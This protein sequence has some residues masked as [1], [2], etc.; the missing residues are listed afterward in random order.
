[1]GLGISPD[2]WL[3]V[4]IIGFD[5]GI[6]VLPELLDGGEGGAVQG[7]SFKDREPD[8]DLI[9]PGGSGRS[10][11]EMHIR[12]TLEPAVVF[13]LVGVEVVEDDV[14]GGVRVASDDIVHE[15]EEFDPASAI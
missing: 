13:G 14:D 5:E 2:E 3:G 6:D 7:L 4:L 12:V 8:L 15:I 1:M 11:V 9:E 10:E